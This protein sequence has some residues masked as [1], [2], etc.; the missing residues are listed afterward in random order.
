MRSE[1]ETGFR[2]GKTRDIQFRREQL[3]SLAYLVQE[4]REA[5]HEALRKDLGRSNYESEMYVG[6]VLCPA[7]QWMFTVHC[8]IEFGGTLG[9]ILT[10]YKSVGKWAKSERAPFAFNFFAMKPTIR[11][12]PK[13]VVLIIV[14]FNYPLLLSL[15]PLVRI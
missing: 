15:G 3:L 4:N 2:T 8:S 6:S 10:A 1:L 11:K 9:E 5:I 7:L 12:E 13:G 14:P